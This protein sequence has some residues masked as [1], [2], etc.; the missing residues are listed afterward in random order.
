MT[1]NV[2]FKT[3]LTSNARDNFSNKL[4]SVLESL[5]ILIEDMDNL[6]A[7]NIIEASELIA[8]NLK[9]ILKNNMFRSN[10]E[11][12]YLKTIQK[13]VFAILSSLDKNEELKPVLKASAEEIQAIL[14]K[15][16]EPINN[17]A[18]EE[19]PKVPTQSNILP[20]ID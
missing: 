1:K 8:F 14:S 11:R 20:P 16:G 15:M 17:I 2:S 3:F 12:S 4:S 9:S 6:K 18:T 13:I 10:E 5:H 19:K 7:K